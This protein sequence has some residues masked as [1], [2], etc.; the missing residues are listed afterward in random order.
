MCRKAVKTQNHSDNYRCTG[1]K[2]TAV[3]IC[4]HAGWIWI[5]IYYIHFSNINKC[6]KKNVCLITNLNKAKVRKYELISNHLNTNG[7]VHFPL[8]TRCMIMINKWAT[9]YF[10]ILHF[11]CW[12]KNPSFA[13]EPKSLPTIDLYTSHRTHHINVSMK[14]KNS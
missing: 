5:I 9:F 4:K 6:K 3:K 14:K 10:P 13:W 1:N 11:A 8:K 2:K 12:K 7:S